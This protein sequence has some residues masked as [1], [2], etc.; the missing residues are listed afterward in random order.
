MKTRINLYTAEFRPKKEKL[1]L[2]QLIAINLVAFIVMAVLIFFA[3]SARDE[4]QAQVQKLDNEIAD[5]R[6]SNQELAEKAAKNIKNPGLEQQLV[7]LN[8]K[9]GYQQDILLLLNGLAD[10]QSSG[11]SVLMTDLAKL[12][13]PDIRLKRIQLN[14]SEMTF[15]G[16]AR[17]H[18]AIP[19]W[20]RQ[21]N[22]GVSL[23]ERKFSQLHIGRNDD[24][25]ITFTLTNSTSNEDAK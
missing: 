10:V 17:N 16:L 8:S 21:F 25:N 12:R 13:D 15:K 7:I 4:V 19:R 6:V 14:N 11:F 23:Q 18:Q 2:A 20:V 3:M 22:Q 24:D 1:N 9:L 5:L